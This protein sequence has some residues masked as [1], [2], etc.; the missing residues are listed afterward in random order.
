MIWRN[1]DIGK[2]VCGQS[3]CLYRFIHSDISRFVSK[4]FVQVRSDKLSCHFWM[5]IQYH[6][7]IDFA[8]AT[9]YTHIIPKLL[10]QQLFRP[11]RNADESIVYRCKVDQFTLHIN[12]GCRSP[13]EAVYRRID[14]ANKE[15]LHIP[16]WRP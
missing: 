3:I 4:V 16:V 2:I 14:L 13:A 12:F 7:A 10:L 6:R 9:P 11:I 15:R 1:K 5:A 8:L